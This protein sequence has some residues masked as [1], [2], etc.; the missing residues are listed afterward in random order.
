M[1]VDG[2]GRPRAGWTPCSPTATAGRSSTGRPAPSPPEPTAEAAAVQ[3]AA[4]RLAW[5][6]IAGIP[7]DQLHT[8]RAAFH[9]VRANETVAPVDLLDADGL[10][11]LIAGRP[12]TVASPDRPAN[13]RA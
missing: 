2:D 12:P 11:A 10:A 9:Y 7:D 5:A 8:V 1:V 13:V 4:Y 3:L 6:R